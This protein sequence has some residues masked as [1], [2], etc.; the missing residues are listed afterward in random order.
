MEFYTGTNIKKTRKEHQCHLCHLAI[1]KKS[2]CYYSCG[3]Y[4]DEFFSRYAH[5]ECSEW[6]T[7]MNDDRAD[8]D[9]LELSEMANEYPHESFQDWKRKIRTAYN[10][11]EESDAS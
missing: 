6:W 2:A 5:N 10:L 1:P 4:Y 3:K 8:D 7:M 11:Q 9:W